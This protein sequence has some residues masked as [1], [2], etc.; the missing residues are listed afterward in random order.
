MTVVDDMTIAKPDMGA[1]EG[2][3]EVI[4]VLYKETGLFPCTSDVHTGVL[5]IGVTK[6]TVKIKGIS[7]CPNHG[8]HRLGALIDLS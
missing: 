8:E 4:T 5:C 1:S 7:L 3:D 6:V 2:D